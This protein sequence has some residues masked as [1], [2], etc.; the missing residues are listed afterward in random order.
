MISLRGRNGWFWMH[1]WPLLALAFVEVVLAA[2]LEALSPYVPA[3]DVYSS[4][5]SF[6]SWFLYMT[7]TWLLLWLWV[8]RRSRGPLP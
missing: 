4:G 7:A 5:P 3:P 2:L 1:R 8:M 6:L